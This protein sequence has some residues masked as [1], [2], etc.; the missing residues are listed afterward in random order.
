MAAY[1]EIKNLSVGFRTFEGIRPVLKIEHLA[2][3][4]GETYGLVGE[5]GAGK[6]VLALTI[7]GLLPK[8]AG[9]IHSG[10]IWLDGENLL[11]KREHEL[12]TIYRGKRLAMIFQDPMSTLNPVFTVGQQIERVVEQQQ[13]LKGS[14]CTQR[15][16]GTA[17]R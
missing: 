8:P 10:E 9:I 15:T 5:S 4:R 12:A 6:T 16:T 17:H 1:F 14:A 13:G 3:E 2:I 7:L 11:K